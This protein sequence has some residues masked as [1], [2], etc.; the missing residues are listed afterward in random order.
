MD[1]PFSVFATAQQH[2]GVHIKIETIV[3]IIVRIATISLNPRAHISLPSLL[4]ITTKNIFYLR[5]LGIEDNPL[6]SSIYPPYSPL[7]P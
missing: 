6:S 7:Q 1:F 3:A 4:A 5:V 2:E